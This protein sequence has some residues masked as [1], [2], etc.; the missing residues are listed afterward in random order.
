MKIVNVAHV[1]VILFAI[2]LVKTCLF[3]IMVLPVF[4]LTIIYIF[5]AIFSN[6][7]FGLY[8]GLFR[9]MCLM[10]NNSK[11]SNHQNNRRNQV[12]NSQSNGTQ[13]CD[14]CFDEKCF[15]KSIK[16]LGNPCFFT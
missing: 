12:Q 13:D 9:W 7:I 3:S 8:F 11:D 4:G 15:I 10:C 16:A 6:L 1:V 5:I 2:C 14:C